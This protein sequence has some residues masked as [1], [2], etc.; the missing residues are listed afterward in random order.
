M[1]KGS[2]VYSVN[3]SPSFTR[4]LERLLTQPPAPA[5]A[6]TRPEDKAKIDQRGHE[7][8]RESKVKEI[9]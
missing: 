1:H 3:L 7:L 5:P 8:F 4:T 9:K 6:P 2:T